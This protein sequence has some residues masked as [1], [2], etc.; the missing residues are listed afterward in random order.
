M[1][2]EITWAEVVMVA[3]AIATELSS[4]SVPEQLML[5]EE[6]YDYIPPIYGQPTTQIMRRYRAAHIGANW[7]VE[8]AGEG[9]YTSEGIGS[10]TFNKNQPVNNPQADEEY[11][12]TIY[13][14]R[15]ETLLAK[16]NKG[17]TVS[18]G[19]FSAGSVSGLPR[20][21]GTPC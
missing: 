14:R 19:L 21:V 2:C 8:T 16:F 6:T 10:V 11:F 1:G 20:L 5:L 13:G 15:V 3:K 12:E 17:K 4:I 9:A 7:F 18:F